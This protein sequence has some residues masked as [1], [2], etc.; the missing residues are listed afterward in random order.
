[1]TKTYATMQPEEQAAMIAAS[2]TFMRTVTNIYGAEAGMEL[3]GSLADSVDPDLKGELFFGMITGKY[4]KNLVTINKVDTNNAVNI[5]KAIRTAT[6][7][8][9]KE[10]KDCY[11]YARDKGPKTIESVDYKI[12]TGLIHALAGFGCIAI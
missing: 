1:M 8:G 11:D 10:A 7:M 4:G 12:A 2:L 5:I 6:G 3:W 9:L